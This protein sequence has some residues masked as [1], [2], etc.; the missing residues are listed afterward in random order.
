MQNWLLLCAAF[1]VQTVMFGNVLTAET[2]RPNVIVFIADDVSWNDYG[3]YGNKAA[4]TPNIDRLAADGIRFDA[5]YLTASSFYQVATFQEDSYR[6]G[7]TLAVLWSFFAILMLL[8]RHYGKRE[9]LHKAVV[10]GAGP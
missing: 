5:A 4:R 9:G 6:S 3:C 10:T 7:I 2:Q 1:T 8:L